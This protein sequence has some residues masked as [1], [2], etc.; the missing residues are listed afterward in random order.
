MG[1]EYDRTRDEVF[2]ELDEIKRELRKIQE[3]Q[4]EILKEEHIIRKETAALMAE[5]ER[6]EEKLTTMKYSDI[7]TWR[8]AIWENCQYKESRP[9]ERMVSY[10]CAKLNAPCQFEHCPLNQY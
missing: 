6:V 1:R 3:Q 8:N 9:S 5:E 4:Q 7:T 2:F 10:W